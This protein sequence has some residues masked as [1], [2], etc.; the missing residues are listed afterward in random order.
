MAIEYTIPLSIVVDENTG[1]L[2]LVDSTGK[3][4]SRAELAT[5]LNNLALQKGVLSS[6]LPPPV[7]P[8]KNP[9]PL[10]ESTTKSE[11]A[12]DTAK[13]QVESTQGVVEET[14][15]SSEEANRN[16]SAGKT[17]EAESSPPANTEERPEGGP[18]QDDQKPSTIQQTNSSILAAITG[19]QDPTDS[20][21][22]EVGTSKKPKIVPTPNLLNRYSSYTYNISLHML[23]KQD[24]NDMGQDPD[25]SWKPSK[26]IVGGAGKW[27]VP[28]FNRDKNFLDDFYFD[29]FK[30]TTIIGSTAGNQG[31][32]AV[33]LS[34]TL[35][36]P[37]GITF[38]D[39]LIDCCNDPAVDGKNYLES[40]YLIQI[41]FYGYDDEGIGQAL[42]KQRKYIPIKLLS[43][44]I[45][46]GIKGAEYSLTAVPYAHGG[47]Q[48][49]VAA[50][51]ANFEVA[52]GT[53]SEFFFPDAN[54]DDT[55][56][57][58]KANQRAESEKAA[59]EKQEKQ[60]PN[61]NN[62]TRKTDKEQSSAAGKDDSVPSYNV[63]SFV[64]AYNAWQERL[65]KNGNAT[66]FNTIKVNISSEILMG[67]NGKG[68][69]I[70]AE[71]AQSSKQ[72]AEKNPKQKAKDANDLARADAGKATA[73]PNFKVG[74]FP[75]SGGTSVIQVINNMMLSSEYIRSQMIDTTKNVQE[76]AEALNKP[77]SWWKVLS[78]V[79]LR[80]FCTQTSKWYMDITYNVIPYTVYNR[81]H[82]N[83]P[84]DLP[85]GWHKEYHYIY[86]GKNDS[87]IDFA[88]EFDTAFYTAVNIDRGKVT[89]TAG[90]QP[91][92]DQ[93]VD[94]TQ[95]QKEKKAKRKGESPV[96]PTKT[97]PVGDSP[98]ETA[99]G[100]QRKDS[101]SMAAA[102]VAEMQ[103]NGQGA[104]QL[105][106]KLR[107]IGDPQFIKQ[108]EIY[109][110][111]DARRYVE[112]GGYGGDYVTGED[113]S[114]A[115]DGGEVHVLLSWKTPVDID[116]E[117]GGLRLEGKYKT[118]A[119]SGIY[120][121][122]V[123]ENTFAQGKFEQNLE[124]IRL[125]DQPQDYKEST[126]ANKDQR[127]D[128]LPSTKPNDDEGYAAL[129]S[130]ATNQSI[131][132]AITKQ[133]PSGG[134]PTTTVKEEN[135][136]DANAVDSTPENTEEVD[137]DAN[138][139]KEISETSETQSADEYYNGNTTAFA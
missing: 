81:S 12:Q 130:T 15:V 129:D 43:C 55:A 89:A 56:V 63:R 35:I 113:S 62:N 112:S 110:N 23:S 107:I 65:V 73:Q 77:I 98:K 119:F 16:K 37:Y 54:A 75:V 88:I 17:E 36:E 123:V 124:L 132:A 117:T 52:A 118:S 79:K 133:P 11:P 101:K 120:R 105:A 106:V 10:P 2:L 84:K 103:N 134:T 40:P 60:D 78:S 102:S 72:V 108:D 115:M 85:T 99:T 27:G 109:Y 31:T 49:S 38:I 51:P 96:T 70:I 131:I 46:A 7:D 33:E 139:L 24:F 93:D 22:T 5:D 121:V 71:Q 92:K 138:Q 32:N 116:E 44:G 59:K 4:L 122:L 100:N 45:K 3:R 47:F 94:M 64:A 8:R 82:P 58:E 30:M 137:K 14:P 41:D 42:I 18:S 53:L 114:I 111:P 66:D 76:N 13:G 97:Q 80:K 135:T 29:N 87:I 104:D 74:K 9:E 68:G 6:D 50:T 21:K 83:A 48:E 128:T 127:K 126:E 26:T 69:K 125:P 86:T 20:K 39:R 95:E 34:F 90:P 57:A 28:G 67:A 25:G 19:K 136:S 1:L 61:K 91:G